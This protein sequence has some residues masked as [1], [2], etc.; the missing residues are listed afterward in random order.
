FYPVSSGRREPILGA[1]GGL[2]FD[3]VR[4]RLEAEYNVQTE[5]EPLNYSAARWVRGETTAVNAVGDGRGRMR[6]EDRDGKIVI[7]FTTEWDLRYAIENADGVE[8]SDVAF[9]TS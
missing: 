8:F 4:Y 2:Q 1:V 9:P 3:V 6:A 5:M 7:L